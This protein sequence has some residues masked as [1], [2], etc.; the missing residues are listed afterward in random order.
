MTELAQG[1]PNTSL[2]GN[3]MCN[4]RPGSTRSSA[5][6]REPSLAIIQLKKIMKKLHETKKVAE[7]ALE[8]A[9]N[10]ACREG[11]KEGKRKQRHEIEKII[12]WYK[13]QTPAELALEAAKGICKSP[14]IEDILK[15]KKP[16]KFTQ[17]K[18]KLFQG[19]TDPI[20]HIYHF[21]NKWCSKEMARPCCKR[22]ND[23]TILFS[24]KQSI[25]ESLKDYLRHFTE[26]MSTF[27]E[28]DSHTA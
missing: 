8:K 6:G 25:R 1:T 22:R 13:P 15:A 5:H 19:T 18:F 26:E 3:A 2:R 27:E 7:K 21:N 16:A 24:T 14:F 17:N 10:M 9:Q 20:E 28:F 23:V 4:L 11:S 12:R